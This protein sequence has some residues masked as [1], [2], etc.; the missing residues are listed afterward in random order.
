VGRGRGGGGPGGGGPA[1]PAGGGGGGGPLSHRWGLKK[2]EAPL[3]FTALNI[4]SYSNVCCIV[5]IILGAQYVVL[6]VDGALRQ[7]TFY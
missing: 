6:V 5:C 1:P 4:H 7:I 2:I 3:I